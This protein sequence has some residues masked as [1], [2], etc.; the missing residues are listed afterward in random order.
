MLLKLTTAAAMM[1][2]LSGPAFAQPGSSGLSKPADPPPSQA[3]IERKKA[4]ERAYQS[5]VDRIPEKGQKSDDPWGGVRS[6]PSTT[7]KK[8]TK[9][10]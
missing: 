4:E 6:A 9:P 2:L 8:K 3:E 1:A 7:V 5:A 10:Q